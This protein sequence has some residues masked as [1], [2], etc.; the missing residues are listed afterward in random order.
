[1]KVMNTE[2][3]KLSKAESYVKFKEN[4]TFE[5]YLSIIEN[6]KH[7]KALT[8]LRLSCHPLLIEKG[9]HHKIPIPKTERFC[10]FCTS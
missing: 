3:G 2:I 10:P 8:R 9:R 4:I 1:M 7:R 5:N 6:E